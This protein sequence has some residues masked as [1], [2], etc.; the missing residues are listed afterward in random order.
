LA[1]ANKRVANILAKADS[2][3]LKTIDAALFA[4]TAEG[5]LYSAIQQVSSKLKPLVSNA[6]YQG[7]LTELSSLRKSVDQFFE[8][9]MVMTDDLAIRNNRLPLLSELR[10]LFLS[11][12]DITLLPSGD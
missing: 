7:A 1:A 8:D 10:N 5:D 12:A 2:S 9:V 4:E 11:V 6:N 3:E